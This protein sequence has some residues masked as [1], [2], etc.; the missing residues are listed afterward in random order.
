MRSPPPKV[1]VLDCD[2]TLW[3]GV[4]SEDGP[5]GVSLDAPHRRLQEFMLQR[6][7][8]GI[9]LCLC[10]KNEERD[11]RVVFRCQPAW[12]LQLEHFTAWRGS[13]G[14]ENR[15]ISALWPGELAPGIGNSLF[16]STTTPSECAE[17][18]SALP[19]VLCLTL[20]AEVARIPKF[21]THV[22][23][24]D[25]PALVT[26]ADKYRANYYHQEA[27][28]EQCRRV[29]PSPHRFSG[30]PRLGNKFFEPLKPVHF[31]RAAQLT[32]K[33]PSV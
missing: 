5:E 21:L 27:A 15:K 25:P 2:H 1:I 29:T 19:E 8:T 20:P 13:I 12:P 6:R 28:R 32:P 33:N 30:E 24:F 18:R 16:L 11:V 31:P 26:E 9:L 10:S 4:C 17:V 22:W 23:A 3:K 7:E 14:C